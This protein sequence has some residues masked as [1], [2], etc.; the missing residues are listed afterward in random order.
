MTSDSRHHLRWFCEG[1]WGSPP[2]SHSLLKFIVLRKREKYKVV[3]W[4]SPLILDSSLLWRS[5]T[6][7]HRNTFK[8]ITEEGQYRNQPASSHSRGCIYPWPSEPSQAE[9]GTCSSG[10]GADCGCVSGSAERRHRFPGRWW[11]CFCL[12]VSPMSLMITQLNLCRIPWHT[13]LLFFTGAL[14]LPYLLS[15]SFFGKRGDS[16]WQLWLRRDSLL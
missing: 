10:A 3:F 4:F 15:A 14:I 9:A 16:A 8:W 6:W 12:S 1:Q 13:S 7:K 11:P 5:V 2:C